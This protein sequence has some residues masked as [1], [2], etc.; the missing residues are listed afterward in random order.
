[1]ENYFHCFKEQTKLNIQKVI[2]IAVKKLE[3]NCVCKEL[4]FQNCRLGK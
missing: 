2:K 4:L 1:M 3:L